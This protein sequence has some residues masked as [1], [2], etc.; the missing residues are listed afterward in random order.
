[1]T[2]LEPRP[3]YSQDEIKQL[4]P[5]Q[6]RLQHVQI[7]L[8]HGERTPIN[9]RF[10]SA[11]LAAYWPY[12]SAARRMTSA[13]LD[14]SMPSS[15]LDSDSNPGIT[16]LEW[17]RRIE[18][19]GPDDSPIIATGQNGE[20][21]AICEMGML[22]DRGRETTYNLGQRLRHLYV[23]QLRFLPETLTT[24][25]DTAAIYLRATPIPRALESLQQAFYG[26]YP[27]STRGSYPGIHPPT[28]LTRSPAHETLFPN[29]GNCRRFATLARAFAERCAERWNDSEEMAYLTK[30]LGRWMP[31]DNPRVAVNSRPRLSGIMD[32]INSTKAHGP[33]TRLPKE[34]Y[35]PEVKRILEK[36]GVEEWY[37]GYKESE[38]YRTLGIG[39]LLGDVVSRM[40]GSAEHSTADGEY[41]L[42]TN[43]QGSITIHPSIKFAM[44]GCHDTT[45]AAT[46]ASLGAFNEEAWPPFTSH[47][48]IELFRHIDAGTTAPKPGSALSFVG[49]DNKSTPVAG[50][51]PPGI[52]R[53]K[54]S[55]LTEEEKERLKGYYVRLRYNDRPVTVPGCKYQGKHLDGDESFCT[56][57]AFKEIVDKFVPTNWR[58]QCRANMRESA[59]PS[60][61]EPSGY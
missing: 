17:K 5:L 48:A 46:L 15:Q 51:P 20:L 33:G 27:P 25:T 2:T 8:R 54:S 24:D 57:E 37:A 21:D 43:K 38:E 36:I 23:N 53:K 42:A 3:P 30:R 19:M 49:L 52:G 6:L 40:V 45:L 12:C 10:A 4:Y 9:A 50:I 11:G 59:F 34:F 39:A 22:T 29:D 56:L 26:L 44:S 58:N 16:A 18:K 28:I 55:D 41:E 31:E 1:M 47:V 35:D 13:I 14:P 7:L 32:T 61:P 60:K